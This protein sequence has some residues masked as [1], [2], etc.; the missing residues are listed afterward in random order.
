VKNPQIF[1]KLDLLI[2]RGLE[3][4]HS[5]ALYELLKDYINI[6]KLRC[7][8]KD[9]KR[10][11]GIKAAQYSNVTMLKKRVLDSAISEINDKTDIVASY[12]LYKYNRTGTEICFKMQPKD[13]SAP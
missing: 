11:M 9:F 8:L 2:I 13:Q 6:G 3:S 7:D 5:V 12:E 10:L 4:K 1:V